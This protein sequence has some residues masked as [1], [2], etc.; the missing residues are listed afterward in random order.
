MFDYESFNSESSF[1]WS[2]SIF[3]CKFLP[4]PIPGPTCGV[5]ILAVL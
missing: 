2:S 5:L 3:L 4:K 1:G